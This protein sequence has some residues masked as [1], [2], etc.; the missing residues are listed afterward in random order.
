ME[1]SVGISRDAR[2]CQRDSGAESVRH[3]VGRQGRQQRHVH[4]CMRAGTGVDQVAAVRGHGDGCVLC[5][6]IQGQVGCHWDASN[7][8]DIMSDRAKSGRRDR[9]VIVIQGHIRKREMAS[10]V[11]RCGPLKAG[12][13]V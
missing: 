5:Q 8:I 3:I 2:R 1:H 11:G 10:R 9:Q 12:D 7:H 13:R 4:V 6:Q